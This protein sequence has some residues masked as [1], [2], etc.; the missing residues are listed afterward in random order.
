M[1]ADIPALN[2]RAQLLLKTLVER[3]ITDGQPVGVATIRP[4]ARWL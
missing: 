3:Y 1:P 2:E 4:S